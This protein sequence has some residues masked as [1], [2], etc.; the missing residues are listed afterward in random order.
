MKTIAC[1]KLNKANQTY[2]AHDVMMAVSLT[3]LQWQAIASETPV[4]CTS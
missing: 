3:S 2:E 4:D 1:K